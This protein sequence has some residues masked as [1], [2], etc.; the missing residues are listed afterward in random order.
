LVAGKNLLRLENSPLTKP[1]AS[2]GRLPQMKT[3]IPAVILGI[4]AIVLAGALYK[5]KHEVSQLRKELSQARKRVAVIEEANPGSEAVAETVAGTA[6]QVA[7]APIEMQGSALEAETHKEK[8]RRVMRNMAKTID[9][10]PTIN[11]MVEASQRGAVG[12]LYSDMLEYL[13]LNPEETKYFMNLLMYRQMANVDVHLKMMAS[14]LAEEEKA[15]LMKAVKLA[16][17]SMLEEMES[18]LNN[19]EDFDEFTFYEDTIGERMMLSQMDQKLGDA[20]LSEEVYREVL[21]IMH[22]ERK[23]YN[24]STD[25]HD[26]ENRDLSP[27]R[28]SEENIQHHITDLNT[29]GEQ[30]DRRMQRILAPEQLT[31]WRESGEAMKSMVAG[32]LYQT[33]QIAG[34]E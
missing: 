20:A 13:D 17:K 26:N 25:L 18:F 6:Y 1:M 9:E 31:A 16:N 22:D 23:N 27:E 8:N 30:M 24:W 3:Q 21:E 19:P 10:N 15:A 34:G 29:L 32:Q 28:F 5:A 7:A 11:K 2:Q 12:A 33:R 4:F 14:D